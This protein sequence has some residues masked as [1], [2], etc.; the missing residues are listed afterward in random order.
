MSF[1]LTLLFSATIKGVI[2]FD[3]KPISFATVVLNNGEY[4]TQ[5]DTSGRFQFLEVSPNDYKLDVSIIGF[6]EYKKVI[7]VINPDQNI[8]LEISLV[9][10]LILIDDIVVTGTKTFKRKTDSPVIVNVLS[11]QTMNEV[12]AC[13]VSEGLKFQPGLRI[14]TDCQ[15]CNYTQL[16]INGLAGGYSQIL[17][18]GRPIFSPLTGL[19]GLEQ[20]PVNM[21]DKIEVVKGGGSSLYGSSAVGGTVNILTKIPTK[22]D[23]SVAYNYQLINGAAW[24]HQIN[25]NTSLVTKNKNSGVSL[26]FNS[27]NREIYD[28]N[29]DNYSELPSLE[30]RSFGANFFSRPTDN[31][32]IELSLSNLNEYRYGGEIGIYPAHLAGQSEERTHNVWMGS[33]DYQ[34]N[35]N[36]GKSSL[37][38]Y[39]AWQNTKRDHYTGIQPDDTEVL[40]TFLENPPYGISNV[41]TYNAGF[42]LNHEI[43]S[44][45]VGSNVLTFGGEYV[46]DKVFDEI[47]AYNYLI[48]QTTQ[49]TGLFIQSDWEFSSKWNLLSG[50]RADRHNFVE[51]TVISPRVSL[52]F[53]PFA[54]TQFRVNYA[55]GF[56]AP[57]AFD[58]DLHI[59][60]A[61][62][63]ISRVS[64]SSDLEQENSLSWSASMNYDKVNEDYIFGY[65]LEGFYTRLED[66]FILESVGEDEFG[67]VFEKKNGAGASVQGLTLELRANYKRKIQLESGFT[68]Q[69]SRNDE[70]VIYIDGIQGT[71][72][73]IRT[74]NN[75]G[76]STLSLNPYKKISVNINYVYTGKMLVPHFAG[77]EN[78]EVDEIFESEAFSELSMRGSYKI[79]LPAVKSNLEL[80]G[81]IKNILNSYQDDFDIGKNRDSNFVYGASMPRTIFIGVR[82]SGS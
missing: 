28:H 30:N 76:F 32:K 15:T 8:E 77:A 66:A 19:Y 25:A 48:D 35:F 6:L 41:S 13:N 36:D 5:S 60:F 58:A 26:F 49:N 11:S 81:G 61:G 57:Q 82:L 65:T 67:E 72:N 69:Q 21:V 64:L 46:Y 43:E 1:N 78:Q 55:K 29:E 33:A 22:N 18:N 75:Y 56:R 24:D 34:L 10:D 9:E 52:L 54:M 38:T 59:A 23:Y 42:Q 17:I 12:Q 47:P 40:V 63:G 39:L 31:Q 45:F 53:K 68:L 70:S 20:L 44:F 7:Q 37:I 62:G 4:V 3:D 27:R 16:R 50:L 14:E 74:P 2:T 51:S 80:F 73:F 71:R 79:G